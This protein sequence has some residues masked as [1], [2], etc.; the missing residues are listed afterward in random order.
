MPTDPGHEFTDVVEQ[1]A[2]PGA[3]YPPFGKYP[4]INNS[5][6]ASNYATAKT[7]GPT[8]PAADIGDIVKCFDTPS[9]L[10]V[11]QYLASQFVV[12]DQWFSSL[13]GPTWPNRFFLHGAS[14]NGLDH[15]PTKE[16]MAE[17]ESVKG[18]RYPNGS[19]FDAMNAAG[20]FKVVSVPIYVH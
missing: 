5:G 9:Q 19:I 11:L 7:E 2:G 1:L 8:P 18:F 4:Q 10:P 17:R 20:E 3:T 13:P 6:F 14:S 12:C 15:S 16:E